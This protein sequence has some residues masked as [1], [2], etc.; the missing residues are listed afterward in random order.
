[1]QATSSIIPTPAGMGAVEIS[2]GAFLT[3]FVGIDQQS[4]VL[5]VLLYRMLSTYLPALPGYVALEFL[6]RKRVV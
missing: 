3:T 5:A 4:A 6:R 1:V 2:M